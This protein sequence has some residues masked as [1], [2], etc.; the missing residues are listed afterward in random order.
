LLALIALDVEFIMM[1]DF[2]AWSGMRIKREKS[3][4][5]GLDFR[6]GTVLPTADI[7]YEGAPLTS[8]AA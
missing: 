4:V 8:L 3:F 6:L 7:L 1:A 2:C 5:I